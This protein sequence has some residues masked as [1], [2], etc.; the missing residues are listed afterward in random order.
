MRPVTVI[1]HVRNVEQI[2]QATGVTAGFELD[3][4]EAVI[5]DRKARFDE[6]NRG[7]SFRRYINNAA[8]RITVQR[9]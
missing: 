8:G 3:L 4:T 9:R 2:V 1:L 7:A 5:P 6:G